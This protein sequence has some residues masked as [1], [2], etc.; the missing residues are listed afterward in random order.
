MA[1]SDPSRRQC[2]EVLS[3]G[4]QSFLWSRSNPP[5]DLRRFKGTD[6]IGLFAELVLHSNF[7]KGLL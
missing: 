2:L 5:E 4:Q 7:F 6:F 1:T 3:T